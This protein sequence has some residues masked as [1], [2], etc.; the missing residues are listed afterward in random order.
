MRL[1]FLTAA[2]AAFLILAFS[3]NSRADDCGVCSAPSRSGS[4]IGMGG[5]EYLVQQQQEDVSPYYAE[6]RMGGLYDSRV[7]SASG[8]ADA[9]EDTALT[10]RLAAGWQSPLMG[11]AGLRIDYRGYMDFHHNYNEFNMIDQSLSLEPLY[12]AGSFIFSLPL[13]FNITFEDGKHDYNKYAVSPTLTYLIPSTRQALALY[14]MVAWI[15]DQDDDNWLDENGKVL[16]GGCAYLYYFENKSRVRLSLDYQHAKYD[17]QVWQ[18]GTSSSIEKR[19]DDAI[20][21]GLDILW[22]LTKHFG[23]FINYSFIHS[24]SNVDLYEYDRHLVEGGLALRF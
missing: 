21:A 13:S 16:G 20:V 6:F 22:Q 5:I 11:N 15:D 19:E 2:T 24:N 1:R 10:S 7:G 12:K 18:Y 17:A 4:L 9:G 23:L 14:G 3:Y 8:S